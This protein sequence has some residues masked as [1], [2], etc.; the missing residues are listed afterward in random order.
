MRAAPLRVATSEDG[1]ATAAV[2]RRGERGAWGAGT[3]SGRDSP[4]EWASSDAF[5]GIWGTDGASG[6]NVAS[7]VPAPAISAPVAI[8]ANSVRW[9]SAAWGAG[10][11]RR[12]CLAR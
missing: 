9:D 2:G 4:A 5:S 6:P 7:A 10:V 11:D 3:A 1:R 12:A 8:D